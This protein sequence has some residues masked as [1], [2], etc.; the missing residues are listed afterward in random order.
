MKGSVLAES[1]RDLLSQCAVAVEKTNSVL[2]INRKGIELHSE[3][4]RTEAMLLIYVLQKGEKQVVY[5]SP[6][7]KLGT[8]RNNTFKGKKGRANLYS[9]CTNRAGI[10]A[11]HLISTSQKGG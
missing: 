4:A 3:F 1:E 8:N 2:G 10:V 9:L 7:S 6:P 11:L 5:S